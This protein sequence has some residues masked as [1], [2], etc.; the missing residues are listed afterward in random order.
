MEN[1]DIQESQVI[2]VN[3]SEKNPRLVSI[4]GHKSEERKS[5]AKERQESSLNF[6][7]KLHPKSKMKRRERESSTDSSSSREVS[8][9]VAQR[10]KR[11]MVRGEDEIIIQLLGIHPHEMKMIQMTHN[12]RG[13]K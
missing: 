4:E 5:L 9:E 1:Q 8:P 7:S 6:I 12:I 10:R 2:I 11:N 3:E 13:L